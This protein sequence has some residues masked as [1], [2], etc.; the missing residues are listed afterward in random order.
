MSKLEGSKAVHMFVLKHQFSSTLLVLPNDRYFFGDIHTEN[1]IRTVAFH[2]TCK[3][4][5]DIYITNIGEFCFSFHDSGLLRSIDILRTRG[6]G[7]I[8]DEVVE[9]EAHIHS[10]QENRILFVNFVAAVFFGRVSGRK[11]TSL[12]GAIYNGQDKVDSFSLSVE[13]ISSPRLEFI[14]QGIREKVKALNDSRWKIF[15]LSPEEIEDAVLYVQNMLAR[16]NEFQHA[17]LQRCMVMNYQAA[18]LHKQQHAAAS[19]VLNFLVIESLV[20]ELFFAYGLVDGS[21]VKSFATRSHTVQCISRKCFKNSTVN[22]LIEKLHEGNLLDDYIHQRIQETRRF[23]NGIMHKGEML[24]P[25]ESGSPQTVVRD[26]W[27]LLI[28]APFE[29]V[30]GYSYRR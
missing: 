8:P 23:R 20:Q 26:L 25:K 9:N 28:D 10:L 15:L 18:I 12:D 29:L 5:A 21:T 13:G 1:E 7:V 14:V 16:H 17:N 19:L 4:I 22:E 2:F 11:H 3:G 6:E 27:I 30:S 24:S